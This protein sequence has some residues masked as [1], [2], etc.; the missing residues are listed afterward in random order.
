[1]PVAELQTWAI[2]DYLSQF[3]GSEVG[4]FTGRLEIA[5]AK[6]SGGSNQYQCFPPRS[7]LGS[8]VIVEDLFDGFLPASLRAGIV[9]FVFAGFTSI[10][11]SRYDS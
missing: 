2:L 10:L 11:P 9:E 3:N 5:V 4:T 6:T 1:M 7:L 8:F